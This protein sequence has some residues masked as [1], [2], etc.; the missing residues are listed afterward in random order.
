MI[1]KQ[2]LLL[3]I[4]VALIS[5][6]T[7]TDRLPVTATYVLKG[8]HA[9][10]STNGIVEFKG[11]SNRL[12]IV[13]G[14]TGAAY[15]WSTNN[16]T[17]FKDMWIGDTLSVSGATSYTSIYYQTATTSGYLVDSSSNTT[18]SATIK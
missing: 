2:I 17:L 14:K 15:F 11:V 1:K 6:C 18:A 10:F 7:K 4:I 12:I 5:G 9:T 13:S 3:L 16:D 8:D